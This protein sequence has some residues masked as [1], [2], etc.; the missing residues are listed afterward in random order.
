MCIKHSTVGRGQVAAP[1]KTYKT[2]WSFLCCKEEKGIL[3]SVCCHGCHG[4]MRNRGVMP[5][6]S[7]PNKALQKN[8]R[9]K[10]QAHDPVGARLDAGP[11]CLIMGLHS[12]KK[13]GW[14]AASYK[15]A[16]PSRP[17]PSCP[18]PHESISL[19]RSLGSISRRQSGGS[20][21]V[22]RSWGRISL[23]RSFHEI[24]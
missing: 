14:S 1:I 11:G 18:G 9:L 6:L 12:V 17:N 21:S 19:C 15:C 20:I 13:A 10:R 8:Y 16:R 23:R 5:F 7:T 3:L 22:R 24:L 4:L 2:S